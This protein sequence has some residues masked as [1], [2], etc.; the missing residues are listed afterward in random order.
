MLGASYISNIADSDGLTDTI[1]SNVEAVGNSVGGI[2]AYFHI[3]YR[4]FFFD[5]E[6]MTALDAFRR[7][8]LPM[9]NGR[10]ARPSVWNIETGYNW[11]WG[12]DLEMAFKYAGSNET[13]ALGLPRKQFGFGLNQE[14]TRNITASFALL[15]DRYH[16]GDINGRDEGHTVL[17]QIAV[18]F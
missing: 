11:N 2:S 1:H 9:A 3:G 13:E 12:R 6:Y 7:A 17:G 4:K 16:A 10:G 14:I 8:E 5:G 18:K 15:R